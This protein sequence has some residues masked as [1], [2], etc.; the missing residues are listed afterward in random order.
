LALLFGSIGGFRSLRTAEPLD[1][2]AVVWALVAFILAVVL[3]GRLP[4][5]LVWVVLPLWWL[6]AREL[7]R[8]FQA[9][10]TA[11]FAV[12]LEAL[13]IFLLL[14]VG[15]LNVASYILDGQVLRLYFTLG[16]LVIAAVATYL[17][18]AGWSG[19]AALTGLV[20]GLCMGML[21][22]VVGE[23]LAPGHPRDGTPVELWQV[24]PASADINLAL[25]TIGDFSEWQTGRRDSLELDIVQADPGMGWYFRS[26]PNA[27]FLE[28]LAPNTL[29]L[30]MLTP[31]EFPDP[32]LTLPYRGQN[33]TWSYRADF[34][35]LP[36]RDWLRWLFYRQAPV[37]KEQVSI[38]ARADMF[39]GGTVL[40]QSEA[41][42]PP[43]E[44]D[45]LPQDSPLQ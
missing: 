33:I 42:A 6:A 11:P 2:L 27:R 28:A 25:S 3:P 24:P 19:R 34:E 37:I 7:A 38:W 9:P 14:L 16:L 31:A 45:V 32:Q 5:D 41:P 1:R 36:A 40:P 44:D 23:A 39:P 22:W 26:F 17:I 15:W 12:L 20:W 18:G 43:S 13:I 29:P 35:N 4:L 30:V 10:L 8:Y 21:I